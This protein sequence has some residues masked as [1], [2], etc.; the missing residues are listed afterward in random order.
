MDSFRGCQYQYHES[1]QVEYLCSYPQCEMSKLFCSECF[2][3]DIHRHEQS[4][5]RHILTKRKF[6]E[7]V[8]IK[9]STLNQ[10]SI[11]P[12]FTQME[13]IIQ[14]QYEQLKLL[15]N[16]I[17]L[18]REEQ[19]HQNNQ[20]QQL[21]E[22]TVNNCFNILSEDV[23][24][25]VLAGEYRDLQ[26]LVN[27]VHQSAG[28]LKVILEQMTLP[29]LQ[30][31]KMIQQL[32]NKLIIACQIS[33]DCKY[34][35]SGG[36]DKKL[37][38]WDFQDK[39][40][41]RSID[42]EQNINVCRFTDDSK[43]LFVGQGQGFLSQYNFQDNIS[44]VFLQKVHDLG[45][46]N[47]LLTK[48]HIYTSSVDKT[49]I[50]MI[51]T[52]KQKLF[53]IQA[54]DQRIDGI[55]FDS[56]N[57]KLI[58]C[59]E[60]RSIKVWDQNGQLIIHESNAHENS[61]NQVQISKQQ[62]ISLDNNNTIC[63]WQINYQTKKLRKIN[64]L[65]DSNGIFNISVLQDHFIR[66]ISKNL[67]K[68]YNISSLLLIKQYYHDVQ[69]LCIHIQY[70]SYVQNYL[71]KLSSGNSCKR[72]KLLPNTFNN[73]RLMKC[74]YYIKNIQDIDNKQDDFKCCDKII[75]NKSQDLFVSI[76]QINIS[77]LSIL[78]FLRYELKTK[79]IPNAII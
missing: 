32:D 17:Q 72:K 66:T 11:N 70:N 48:E 46:L 56:L 34:I 31:S 26:R 53:Q 42:Q 21:Q 58:T 55:C 40:L 6:M 71:I 1:Y 62:L 35:A 33:N 74:Y 37:N 52:T 57:S 50:K 76:Q 79:R 13:D 44:Q 75:I 63:L 12:I 28:K 27:Q 23:I 73:T 5:N 20:S 77:K 7:L 18:I 47:I 14:Q 59:S 30:C 36:D 2:A 51:I 78:V 3:D 65:Y 29:K 43:Q 41:I 22:Y 60:D 24:Q 25:Q 54:H 64:Q 9:L 16:S 19:L 67:V 38:I 15:I 8:N 49:I 10:Q 61:I 69:E 39:Y 4:N 45:I 68:I